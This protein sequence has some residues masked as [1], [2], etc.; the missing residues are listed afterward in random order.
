MFLRLIEAPEDGFLRNCV[1]G[2]PMQWPGRCT[3]GTVYVYVAHK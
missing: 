3:I 2:Y 1:R